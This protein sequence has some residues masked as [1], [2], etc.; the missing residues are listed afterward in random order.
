MKQEQGVVEREVDAR[1][2]EQQL[3]N[4][5]LLL[6]IR[7]AAASAWLLVCWAGVS[8]GKRPDMVFSSWV[9][10]GALLLALGALWVS[11][12]GRE[13]AVVQSFWLV[14]LLDLPTIFVTQLNAV[15]VMGAESQVALAAPA[16]LSAASTM[17]LLSL[18]R[19]FF[20]AAAGLA[21]VFQLLILREAGAGPVTFVA[22][23]IALGVVGASGTALLS[24]AHQLIGSVAREGLAKQRLG[25][26]FSPAVRS[27]ITAVT[28]EGF[29]G[30][31]REVT[32]LFSDI[33]GFTSM[34]EKMESRAV[35]AMLNEYHS[36]MVTEVFRHGGTLDKFI[37]DGLMAYFGAPVAQ[38]G[39]AAAAVSCAQAMQR[40]LSE[41]NARRAARGEGPLRIG[42]GL[43]TGT[44]TVGDIG[45]DDRRE[46][47]AVGDAV[48]LASRIEGLTKKVGVTVLVSEATRRAAG[49]GFA[50]TQM[51]PL[52]VAG[53]AEP[54]LT[55]TLPEG[56]ATNA[57]TKQPA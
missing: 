49:D 53:K 15:Q 3:R 7:V 29:T 51:E 9:V 22:V 31:S 23:S 48:N 45:S 26:Y 38:P 4:A 16:M 18:R 1:V 11:G 34:S 42:I 8:S 13:E 25:R 33:R 55:W 41:L 44:V 5:R 20:A 43:H 17:A 24:Q 19:V 52:P 14:P 28:D 56:E 12:R 54:V 39:H 32:L 57:G 37:G 36:A 46:Y 47:T 6:R 50:W 35:V 10:G 40:A 21:L 30:E 2:R 27:Q